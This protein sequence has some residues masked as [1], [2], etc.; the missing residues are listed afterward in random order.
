MTLPV[1]LRLLVEDAFYID[2]QSVARGHVAIGEDGAVRQSKQ[3]LMNE[4]AALILPSAGGHLAIPGF[5]NAFSNPR[6]VRHPDG[7]KIAHGQ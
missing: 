4:A 2:G 3:P 7:M 1:P 5:T 6:H